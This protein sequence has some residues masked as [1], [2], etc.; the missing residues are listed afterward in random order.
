MTDPETLDLILSRAEGLLESILN[1]REFD[2]L[3]D[4]EE[5]YSKITVNFAPDFES[6]AMQLVDV[7]GVMPKKKFR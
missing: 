7:E 4:L 5:K 1:L 6:K 2:H 3:K